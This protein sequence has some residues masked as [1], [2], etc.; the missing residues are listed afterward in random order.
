[1]VSPRFN[2]R[3]SLVCYYL[4][5]LQR[6]VFFLIGVCILWAVGVDSMFFMDPPESF[7]LFPDPA[8]LFNFH[9]SLQIDFLVQ[10]GYISFDKM[11]GLVRF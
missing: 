9:L 8:L 6:P 1:M 11:P 4:V 3:H 5:A 10:D 7:K 2:F